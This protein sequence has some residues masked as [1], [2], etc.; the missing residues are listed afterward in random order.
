MPVAA[1]P[2]GAP[3]RIAVERL[4]NRPVCRP[5]TRYGRRGGR[6]GLPVPAD[7]HRGAPRTASRPAAARPPSRKHRCRGP[8]QRWTAP[9]GVA[10]RL[11][12]GL[13]RRRADG[14][15]ARASCTDARRVGTDG[16]R[17]VRG[18]LRTSSDGWARWRTVS[19]AASRRRRTGFSGAGE[20]PCS[21]PPLPARLPTAPPSPA[22]V[23]AGGSYSSGSLTLSP[24]GHDGPLQHQFGV[25]DPFSFALSRDG[26]RTWL[27][28]EPLT[29]SRRATAQRRPSALARVPPIGAPRRSSTSRPDR[30]PGTRSSEGK[31][32]RLV[33]N[34]K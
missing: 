8:T 4:P 34:K 20:R 3:A 24:D 30:A 32:K 15:R 27:S 14:R 18:G 2:V 16:G 5:G 13:A 25:L 10:E 17:L 12:S 22:P 1:R 9:D 6:S 7:Q 11:A 28:R 33:S 21:A 23:P 26:G 31:G 19:R 29:P